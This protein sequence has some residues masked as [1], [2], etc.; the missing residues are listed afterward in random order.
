[1]TKENEKRPRRGA[2]DS[3]AGGGGLGISPKSLISAPAFSKEGLASPIN[4]RQV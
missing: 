1:M 2:F 3:G 4:G